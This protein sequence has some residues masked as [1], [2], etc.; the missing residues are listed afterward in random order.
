M[1]KSDYD[2]VQPIVV[3]RSGLH[4]DIVKAAALASVGAMITAPDHENWE[5]WLS[6]RFAKTVRRARPAQFDRAAE[7]AVITVTCGDAEA[8]GL[9]PYPKD[10]LP[11]GVRKL[12]VSGLDVERGENVV[13]PDDD[14]TVLVAVD[15]GLGL[16]TGKTAAQVAHGLF[17][18]FLGLE[19]V[20]RNVWVSSGM[21]FGFL[22]VPTKEFT[23]MAETA[24]VVI[25]DAGFTEIAPG[26]ATV[27]VV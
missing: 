14:L 1:S 25:R 10:D 27:L 5:E 18:W 12:Q 4:E 20:E 15:A 6:G 11:E 17:R 3:R 2:F 23:V 13:L 21:P 24:Q 8:H 26:T 19:E 7:Y 16:T 9:P 22:E